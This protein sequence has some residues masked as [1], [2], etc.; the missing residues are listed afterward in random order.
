VSIALYRG[1]TWVGGPL[2][3]SYM[4]KRLESGREDPARQGERFG[5]PSAARP[6]GPLVWIHAASVGESL[7]VLTLVRRLQAE[8]PEIAI[9]ITSGT[10]T[11]ARLLAERLPAG[12]IHQYVPVDRVPWVKRFLNHWRPDLVLW[13]ESEF[14]PTLL[15]EVRRR[16]IPAMLVNARISTR[17]W[18]GWRRAPWM[19]RRLLATFDV[20][21]AQTELYAERLRD[22]GAVR[23]A[24]PGNLKFAADPLPA[25]DDAVAEI[26]SRI[27][28]R[29]RWAAISTHPGEEE[30]I[31]EAHERMARNI[32]DILTVIVPRHPGR[33]AAIAELLR[34]R[35]LTVSVRSEGEPVTPETGIL[36]ANTMGELGLFFRVS[37]IAFIGGSLIPH[38]GQ[39]PIEPARLGCAIVHGPHMENFLAIEGELR[40]AGASE[41]VTG[42]EELGRAVGTL[43]SNPGLRQRRVAAARTVAE[44]KTGI[45]DAVFS[46]LDPALNRISPASPIPATRDARA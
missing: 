17:S 2:I 31:A 16:N 10:V 26:E 11:S 34:A 45:L 19:I 14:W 35:G 22:L 6:D 4:K 39:N 21:M 42:A 23:V 41:T 36:L 37:D 13:V 18:R 40:T 32:P 24:C 3:R 7:S 20:C 27:A 8:R 43:L 9:L 33:G 38:G 46:H 28:A 44:G 1:L 29:P 15:S 5:I 30:I 12:V 25:S